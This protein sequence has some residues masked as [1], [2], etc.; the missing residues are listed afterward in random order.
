[1]RTQTTQ[2]KR[3]NNIENHVTTASEGNLGTRMRA[4][5]SRNYVLKYVGETALSDLPMFSAA[6]LFRTKQSMLNR[7]PLL[8]SSGW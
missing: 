2:L 7:A 4:A 8:S 1:M 5:L 6:S 3:Q